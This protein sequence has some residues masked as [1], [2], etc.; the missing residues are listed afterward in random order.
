MV[1]YARVGLSRFYVPA[2]FASSIALARIGFVLGKQ[3]PDLGSEC[4]VLQHVSR[5]TFVVFPTVTDDVASALPDSVAREIDAST[6]A[7]R[8]AQIAFLTATGGLRFSERVMVNAAG[9]VIDSPLLNVG[10]PNETNDTSWQI[11][12]PRDAT[13]HAGAR[14]VVIDLSATDIQRGGFFADGARAPISGAQRQIE[15]VVEGVA[16]GTLRF[17]LEMNDDLLERFGVGPRF[18]SQEAVE[19]DTLRAGSS[20]FPLYRL[21]DQAKVFTC[22][23]DLA[24]PHDDEPLADASGHEA[25]AARVPRSLLLPPLEPLRTALH[26]VHGAEVHLTADHREGAPAGFALTSSPK[27]ITVADGKARTLVQSHYFTPIGTFSF[28]PGVARRQRLSLGLSNLET[29]A[30][31]PDLDKLTFVPGHAAYDARRNDL[32][33]SGRNGDGPALIDFEGLCRTSWLRLDLGGDAAAPEALSIQ[34]EG[35]QAYRA[36]ADDAAMMTFSATRFPTPAEPFPLAPLLGVR[37]DSAK[38]RLQLEGNVIAKARRA[39]LAGAALRPES[40]AETSVAVESRT[41]QGFVAFRSADGA[42]WSKLLFT[43]TSKRQSANGGFADLGDVELRAT[44]ASAQLL[45]DTMSQNRLMLVTT[46]RTLQRLAFDLEA[47][48]R[49]HV[50]GWGIQLSPFADGDDPI[51]VIKYDSRPLRELAG[52]REQWAAPDK[53]DPDGKLG[54]RL[55]KIFDGAKAGDDPLGKLA[56]RIDDPNWNGL[57]VLDAKLPLDGIPDQMRAI[58]AGL[59]KSLPVPYL[60]LDVSGI[61]PAQPAAEPWRSAL[62]GLVHHEDKDPAWEEDAE[63]QVSMRVPRLILRVEN[64]AIDRF[65]CMIQLRLPRLFEFQSTKPQEILEL[66][67]RYESRVSNGK[68][69]DAYIF[70]AAGSY[71]KDFGPKSVVRDLA[72]R[73]LRLVTT[74]SEGDYTEGRFL[75][76]GD[77]SFNELGGVDLLGIE[78]LEFTDLAIDLGFF[79]EG[80]RR[81]KLK[82]N[83][84]KLNFDLAGFNTG[85]GRRGGKLPGFL[86]SFPLKLKGLRFGDFDLQSLGFLRLGNLVSTPDFEIGSDFKFAL[87][88]DLDLGSLGSLAKKLERFK[89]QVLVGWKPIWENGAFKMNRIAAGFRI[90]LGEGGGGIDLGLQDILRLRAERFNFKREKV[91]NKDLIILSADDCH[92]DVLGNTF[93][94]DGKFSLFL[95]ANLGDPN[96][97]ERP[98]WYASFK[99][100]KAEPPIAIEHLVMAQRV[101]VNLGDVTTTRD[102]LAW[103][104]KQE[105]FDED[106]EDAAKKFVKFA[107]QQGVVKYDRSRDWFI[108]LKGDFFKVCRIAVLLKDPDV[109]GAYVGLLAKDDPSQAI[110]SFDLLYQKLA[111]GVGRYVVELGLPPG[112]RTFEVGVASVTLGMIRFEIFTDGGF[113]VDLG[114]PQHVDYSRSFAVQAFIFIGK[115]GLYL[116][117]TP[118]VTVPGIPAGYGPVVRTGFAMKVG[119]GREFEYGPI[120]AGLSL[121]VFGRTEGYF[122][123]ASG[124]RKPD[125]SLLAPYPYWMRLRGEVGIIAEIEGSVDLRLIRARLLLR[126]WVATGIVLETALPVLL[127]CE[128]GVSVAVEFEIA[129]FKVFGKRIRITVMLRYSTTLRFEYTLPARVPAFGGGGFALEAIAGEAP[130]ADWPVVMDPKQLGVDATPM[131]LRLVYDVARTE[132]GKLVAIP[133]LMWLQGTGEVAASAFPI[134]NLARGLIGWAA[135]RSSPGAQSALEIPIRKGHDPDLRAPAALMFDALESAVRD[136]DEVPLDK[137]EAMLSLVLIGS[138]I[139]HVEESG[140]QPIEGYVLPIPFG[141][142]I[143]SESAEQTQIF[144]YATVGAIGE[145]AIASLL[146]KFDHQFMEIGARPT[147]AS[148]FT[149]VEQPLVRYL[150]RSWCTALALAALDAARTEWKLETAFEDRSLRDVLNVVPLAQWKNAAARAG[151]LLLSGVRVGDG[152]ASK[153]LFDRAGLFIG[154]PT[155]GKTKLRLVEPTA[156]TW[157]GV[158]ASELELDTARIAEMATA[159]V[160]IDSKTVRPLAVRILPRRFFLPHALEVRVDGA[161]AMRLTRF[162]TDLLAQLGATEFR[163]LAF[164]ARDPAASPA[165]VPTARVTPLRRPGATMAFEIGLKRVTSGQQDGTNISFV[166]GAYR[167]LGASE[168]DRLGLD[169][170]MALGTA[171]TS[172]LN[173]DG[174]QLHIGWRTGSADDEYVQMLPLPGD[175]RDKVLVTRSTVSVQRRPYVEALAAEA[176]SPEEVFRSDFTPQSRYALIYLLQ[177][178]AIVNGTGTHLLLPEALAKPLDAFFAQVAQ[179]GRDRVDLL[180]ILV[181]ADDAKLPSGAFNAASFELPADIQALAR[182]RVAAV[183]LA[184]VPHAGVAGWQDDSMLEAVA[185][186]PAGIELVRTWRP[187]VASGGSGDA[188]GASSADALAARFD[189]LEFEVTDAASGT[190]LIDA[191]DALPQSSEVAVPPE[192]PDQMREWLAAEKPAGFAD[193]GLRY[194]ILVPVSKLLA[195]KKEAAPSPYAAIGMTFQIDLRWRDVYGN[196]LGGSAWSG[197]IEHR[198]SDPLVPVSA[199]PCIQTRVYPGAAG[200][201]ELVLEF[202]VDQDA[203]PKGGDRDVLAREL[204]R[205]LHQ[206]QDP[207]TSI[208]A[209]S[210]LQP[211]SPTQIDRARL[212]AFVAQLRKDVIAG[213]AASDPRRQFHFKYAIATD[214]PFHEIAFSIAIDRPDHLVGHVDPEHGGARI[215]GAAHVQSRVLL[216]ASIDAFDGGKEN[217]SQLAAEFQSAFAFTQDGEQRRFWLARGAADRAGSEWWAIDDRVFPVAD[218]TPAIAYA[219]PPLARALMSGQVELRAIKRLAEADADYLQNTFGADEEKDVMVRA[220][221]RDVDQLMSDFLDQVEAFLSAAHAPV[222]ATVPALGSTLVSPFESV[223]RQK[224]RLLDIRG[225]NPPLLRAL[226]TVFADELGT[227]EAH[228]AARDELREACAQH[229]QRFYEVGCVVSKGLQSR[230]PA[231]WFTTSGNDR[232]KVYGQLKFTHGDASE[233]GFR[234]MTRGIPL[235]AAGIQLAAAVIPESKQSSVDLGAMSFRLT[236]VERLVAVAEEGRL[237]PSRWLTLVPL[238]GQDLPIINVTAP[239]VAPFP[240]RRV[241]KA[242]ALERPVVRLYNGEPATTYPGQ[243]ALARRW[244]YGFEAAAELLG[245]DELCGRLIYNAPVGSVPAALETSASPLVPGLFEALVAHE[246]EVEP[247]WKTII[248]EAGRRASKVHAGGADPELRFRNACGR[249]SRSVQNVVDAFLKVFAESASEAVAQDRFVLT[250]EASTTNIRFIDHMLADQPWRVVAGEGRPWLRVRQI[251]SDG[252]HSATTESVVAGPA[253]EK[254]P[255]EAAFTFRQDDENREWRRRQIDVGRLDALRQ[256][257]VWAAA[258]V[259][260][261]DKIANRKARAEFVYRTPEVFLQ[262]LISP[263]LLRRQ[264][265]RLSPEANLSLHQLLVQGLSPVI[266][267]AGELTR[268][269]QV[270]ADYESGQLTQLVESAIGAVADE[271]GVSFTPEPDP[272]L[273]LAGVRVGTGAGAVN[274]DTLARTI[275]TKLV[276]M[277]KD[278]AIATRPDGERGC[279]VL[280]ITIHTSE[281]DRPGLPVLRL[282]RLCLDLRRVTGL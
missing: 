44:P 250:H 51:V 43:R 130:F 127:Y 245:G 98:G 74:K 160:S 264:T 207:N 2:A 117:R 34:P 262:E 138:K 92:L 232:P 282:Q 37:G 121:C 234:A 233:P 111:D 19:E 11:E 266:D 163:A 107:G 206:L 268:F 25:P 188:T 125:G 29:V 178:A 180:F 238:P 88:F 95:F 247:Y 12:I 274:V 119:L 24:A 149:A 65:E 91:G 201:R 267:D 218:A 222:T 159:K 165:P 241:P 94:E 242:P 120:R 109:Y 112:Y 248:G 62:F 223:A 106:D 118:A 116:G 197:T 54:A 58:A 208:S 229:L 226:M 265:I 126:I 134:A 70:E 278:E 67:G 181:F 128:A 105:T 115:G 277:C 22:Q 103:I 56:H 230:A 33:K 192:F 139:A 97:F 237:A 276:E 87:E 258:S 198:Y 186:R 212:A 158:D 114:F 79:V 136:L 82:F 150:F 270:R 6:P 84:P 204:Q 189:M 174:T 145:Q 93:P 101:D 243:V 190:R 249:F 4:D 263:N 142:R 196:R 187:R 173:L 137:F 219:L 148:L 102:A 63:S 113:L 49:M 194:D 253:T 32:V 221:D 162:S 254:Q 47:F 213:D 129:S 81:L 252:P 214:R 202:A 60:G 57:L 272:K 23:I 99:D 10:N 40:F 182:P 75:I 152:G 140:D 244:T 13:V 172:A 89:L 45:S 179:E 18:F 53:F 76:D 220:V 236:H 17:A 73:R 96:P 257:T 225:E 255:V 42:A 151:R 251:R 61:D 144:D 41:P 66:Q 147:D 14:G 68:R 205:I 141:L 108:A 171:E 21:G 85:S 48:K 227:D 240:V 191:D 184:A 200:S 38:Q 195:N 155:S 168:G 273:L 132:I 5:G 210:S 59:P 217:T 35:M 30:V 20:C 9:A 39:R 185:L 27:A 261:N 36:A 146:D 110:M 231:G 83:Y 176:P 31:E 104:G 281:D 7:G 256:Q 170:I 55:R 280:N 86:R 228:K 199:W 15:L 143:E 164:T 211:G 26:A 131:D 260:R 1:T 124:E 183:E 275:E 161:A 64:D 16:R 224:A 80:L 156:V 135:L 157:F 279:V 235:E 69:Y 123:A 77:I 154:V 133:S 259:R 72:L 50:G 78:N 8:H 216:V 3:Q 46:W 193:D 246:R 269:I 209:V 71:R 239:G 215:P 90:D 153:A 177:R 167:I 52:V 169:A 203:V 100:A 122:A 175:M 271:P 166:P 28:K